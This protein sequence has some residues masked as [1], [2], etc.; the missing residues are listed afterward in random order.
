VSDTPRVI[1]EKL[2]D[3]NLNKTV[4]VEP[5]ASTSENLTAD[6]LPQ[7]NGSFGR[8]VSQPP[9]HLW[10]CFIGL[11]CFKPKHNLNFCIGGRNQLQ[12]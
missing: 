12:R 5:I 9:I 10:V 6:D 11:Y 3:K 1:P 7:R 2:D 4:A 8:L